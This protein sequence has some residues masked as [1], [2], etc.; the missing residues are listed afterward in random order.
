MDHGAGDGCIGPGALL[1]ALRALGLHPTEAEVQDLI[2]AI[3]HSG[4]YL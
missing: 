3:D 1:N 2:G 4:I